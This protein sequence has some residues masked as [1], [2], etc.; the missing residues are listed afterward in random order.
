MAVVE[1]RE[2]VRFVSR[3]GWGA[4]AARDRTSQQPGNI[5][6]IFVHYSE[7]PGGQ[8]SFDAQKQ[9]VQNIQS[10]HMGPERGWSDI[11]YS[12]LVINSAT[13]RTF[14]GRGLSAVP[15]AQQGYNTNSC[16]ICVIMAD[17]EKLRWRTKIQ[18]RRTIA[19][20]RKR[21]G[22]NVPVLPHKA[23]NSTSCPG[24]ALTAWVAKTY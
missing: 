23:V 24:E 21:I 2:F 6:R 11:A 17:G 7:S 16:A 5:R 13:S 12:Y 20:V 4:K 1:E 19:Q 9:A 22:K 14:V 10:F 18:L 3:K 15:A 8:V